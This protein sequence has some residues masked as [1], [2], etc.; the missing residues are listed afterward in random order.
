MNIYIW[1]L[2]HL[3]TMIFWLILPGI[4]FFQKLIFIDLLA[5]KG[6]K[7]WDTFMKKNGLFCSTQFQIL[8]FFVFK[9]I[10]LKLGTHVYYDL[11]VNNDT[12]DFFQKF[13]F[14]DLLTL[15]WKK[16]L[17]LVFFLLNSISNVNFFLFW[18]IQISN[19]AHT[20]MMVF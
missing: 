15:L 11:L 2:V 10:T 4:K 5:L 13:I 6:A 14:M 3:C 18:E 9:D 7:M 12:N 16:M 1:N 20:C 17:D 19:L 8:I